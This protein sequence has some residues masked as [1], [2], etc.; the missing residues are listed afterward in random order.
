[1]RLRLRGYG[2]VEAD[3]EQAERL[4]ALGWERADAPAKKAPARKR[5]TARKKPEETKE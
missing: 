5:A 4:L 2:T 3:G 1:M